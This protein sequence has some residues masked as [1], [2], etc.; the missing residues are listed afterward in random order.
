MIWGLDKI[1]FRSV[2]ITATVLILGGCAAQAGPVTQVGNN[3]TGKVIHNDTLASHIALYNVSL[4][5][6]DRRSDLIGVRGAMR[7]KIDQ[8]CEGWVTESSVY[9]MFS[10]ELGQDVGTTWTFASWEAKDGLSYRFRVRQ[11]QNGE[12]IE[13]LQGEASREAIGQVGEARFNIP[14]G[15]VITLPEGFLF[16]TEHLLLAMS[17]A[18][19][20]G[21]HLNKVVFDGASLDNPYEISALI[22]N[23][24][25]PSN[26]PQGSEDLKRIRMSFHLVEG[27]NPLPEFE[28]EGDY[29]P[30]GIAEHLLQDFG[31]FTLKLVPQTIEIVDK[32]V[33]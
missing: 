26:Q 19:S 12:E 27:L 18:N 3:V 17:E 8:E 20:G 22:T 31:E 32:P 9:M 21:I 4:G 16:P 28:L 25:I 6:T 13:V 10:Y 1:L 5:N 29:R 30:N 7:Y 33:C 14:K 24:K 11:T 23:K 15:I 2:C